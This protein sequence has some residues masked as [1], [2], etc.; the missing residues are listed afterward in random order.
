MPDQDKDPM[1]R[2]PRLSTRLHQANV[3]NEMKKEN[4]SAT[5]AKL[6]AHFAN[7]VYK[8]DSGQMLDYKKLVIH[9]KKETYKWWQRSSA[10]EFGKLMK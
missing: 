8:E 6:P 7:A 1:R 2:V 4:K 5:R 3:I 10:N 9:N